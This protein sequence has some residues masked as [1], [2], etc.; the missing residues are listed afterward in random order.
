MLALEKKNWSR[1]SGLNKG[2]T[3]KAKKIKIKNKDKGLPERDRE[4]ARARERNYTLQIYP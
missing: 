1:E 2:N 4:R 3:T